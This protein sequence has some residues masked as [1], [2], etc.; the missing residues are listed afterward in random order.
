M[1]EERCKLEER[2]LDLH[3]NVHC[4][5]TGD[6]VCTCPTWYAANMI[7]EALND[8]AALN[9]VPAPS[10]TGRDRDEVI[11]ECAE[12]IE[13][14][15]KHYPKGVFPEPKAGEHGKTRDACSASAIRACCKVLASDV[16]ALK[17]ED[18]S[19]KGGGE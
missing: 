18:A 15:A 10:E 4:P 12:I 16:R 6:L 11:E 2:K 17:N 7:C 1:S 5:K 9:A 13:A 3:W 14:H 8:R 19:G